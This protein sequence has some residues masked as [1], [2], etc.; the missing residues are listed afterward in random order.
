VAKATVALFADGEIP[1]DHT[2]AELGDLFTE[3]ELRDSKPID[4]HVAEMAGRFAVRQACCKLFARETVLG[5]IELLTLPHRRY[6]VR[7]TR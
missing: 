1:E 6:P 7:L 3:E 5:L 2:D 4:S